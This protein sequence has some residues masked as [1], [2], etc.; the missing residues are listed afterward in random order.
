M[1]K[2]YR[3]AGLGKDVALCF[4]TP[5]GW[6]RTTSHLEKKIVRAQ[7]YAREAFRKPSANKCLWQTHP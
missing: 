1:C 6:R 4:A 5:N 7:Q 3:F 2:H